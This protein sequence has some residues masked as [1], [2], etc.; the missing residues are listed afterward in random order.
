[1]DWHQKTCCRQQ[2]S[3]PRGARQ[4]GRSSRASGQ[5]AAHGGGVPHP[6]RG[7]RESRGRAR[8]S[9][10]S[11]STYGRPDR[12]VG[13]EPR[14]GASSTR[15]PLAAWP[16]RRGDFPIDG[17]GRQDRRTGLR[18]MLADLPNRLAR[19]GE[20]HS[21]ASSCRVASLVGIIM[22][23][24]GI[25]SLVVFTLPPTQG[26]TGRTVKTRVGRRASA[27]RPPSRTR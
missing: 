13:I 5:D 10:Y 24:R 22:M 17:L 20:H 4:G 1:M 21:R 26:R 15:G 2:D 25:P 3:T 8:M 9:R 7:G 11:A 27:V 23:L 19:S 14:M 6:L 18:S 12:D 16:S